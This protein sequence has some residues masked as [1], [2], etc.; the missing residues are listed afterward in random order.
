[1]TAEGAKF[2]I[3][4]VASKMGQAW[5]ELAEASKEEYTKQAKDLKQAYNKEYRNF[6]EGLSNEAIKEI[7]SISGKKLRIPG[8]K[9]A[10]KQEL[11]RAAGSP[12]KPLTAFFEFMKHFRAE[13]DGDAQGKE[14]AVDMAKQA[15][16]KW[17]NM[18]ESEKQVSSL[19]FRHGVHGS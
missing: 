18:S 16:E 3:K 14:R 19:T 17:K 12:G 6:L 13:Y 9:K 15:G 11:N 8:G 2:S 1:V 5:N 4:D 10:R 7:E